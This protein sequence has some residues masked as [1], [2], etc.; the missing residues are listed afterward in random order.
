MIAVFL[1]A[2]MLTPIAGYVAHRIKKNDENNAMMS[3]VYTVHGHILKS[4]AD[5]SHKTGI[6]DV[7]SGF[8]SSGEFITHYSYKTYNVTSGFTVH[9]LENFVMS[10][11]YEGRKHI[12]QQPVTLFHS[13]NKDQTD[14]FMKYY[15]NTNLDSLDGTLSY[16]IDKQGVKRYVSFLPD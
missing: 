13:L 11:L 15:N 6:G 4:T 9:F 7:G 8:T 3:K 14:P 12:D 1:I 16:V 10:D 2:L 5:F